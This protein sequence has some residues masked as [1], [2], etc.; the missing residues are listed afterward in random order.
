MTLNH[1]RKNEDDIGPGS[2]STI[3]SNSNGPTIPT[4]SSAFVRRSAKTTWED[5]QQQLRNLGLVEGMSNSMSNGTNSDEEKVEDDLILFLQNEI[6]P[7]QASMDEWVAD[8]LNH[9]NTILS[10]LSEE[11]ADAQKKSELHSAQEKERKQ[12][13][14]EQQNE[15][16]S[17]MNELQSTEASIKSVQDQITRYQQETTS[18]LEAC[19]DIEENRRREEGKLRRRVALYSDC[20]GIKWN[21]DADPEQSIEALVVSIDNALFGHPRAISI[22]NAPYTH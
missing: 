11:L 9:G 16:L 6:L 4:A 7:M 18:E 10:K 8:Q 20:T 2:S 17:L 22:I 21:Y 13:L 15:R 19:E 1:K 14:E 12:R 5:I 3:N